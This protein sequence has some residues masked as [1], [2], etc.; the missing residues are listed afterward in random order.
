MLLLNHVPVWS[1]RL[2]PRKD[3][4]VCPLLLLVFELILETISLLSPQNFP[5]L[6]SGEPPMFPRVV[7]KNGLS[8]YRKPP[9]T[10]S[11]EKGL[12]HHLM[13]NHFEYHYLI[14]C[15]LRAVFTSSK[16][17]A[18]PSS[19]VSSCEKKICKKKNDVIKKKHLVVEKEQIHSNQT[20]DC[21]APAYLNPQGGY[22]YLKLPFTI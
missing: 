9:K 18:R 3:T 21:K 4:A 8:I 2:A 12:A 22:H 15:V 6:E 1:Q 20:L 10:R 7:Q 14:G 16:N 5:A 17:F 11:A 19:S 13:W